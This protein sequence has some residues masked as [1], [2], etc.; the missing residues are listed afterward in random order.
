MILLNYVSQTVYLN[1]LHSFIAI[2]F[3]IIHPDF[4]IILCQNVC[5]TPYF[6]RDRITIQEKEREEMKAKEM[7]ARTKELAEERKY[8]ARK[9]GIN[10]RSVC[11]H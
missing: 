5:N 9:V 7:E 2:H 10:V 6:R 4:I 11:I 8:Q 3:I 1:M